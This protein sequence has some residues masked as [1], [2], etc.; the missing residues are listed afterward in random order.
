MDAALP[1]VRQDSYGAGADNPKPTVD[2]WEQDLGPQVEAEWKEYQKRK[3]QPKFGSGGGSGNTNG[4]STESTTP[5]SNSAKQK[6]AE[7]KS[8]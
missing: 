2:L 3:K 8:K 5:N 6:P 1:R 7:Q 4:S